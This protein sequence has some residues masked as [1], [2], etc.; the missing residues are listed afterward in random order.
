MTHLT[1]SERARICVEVLRDEL[2][3]DAPI[4]EETLNRMR[5]IITEAITDAL[6]AEQEKFKNLPPSIHIHTGD[7]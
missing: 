3:K 2:W 6:I 1:S 7:L 4:S 5:Y